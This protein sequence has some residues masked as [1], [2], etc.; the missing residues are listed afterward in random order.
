MASSLSVGI[1][2][3]H[4]SK[5][6]VLYFKPSETV[7]RVIDRAVCE[8]EIDKRERSDLTLIHQGN[9]LSE[10]S[11]VQVWLVILIDFI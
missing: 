6:K 5:R 11:K 8:L 10:R 3:H 9:R 2:I 7:Q 4:E 1:N